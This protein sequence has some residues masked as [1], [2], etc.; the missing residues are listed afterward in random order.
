MVGGVSGL[1]RTLLHLFNGHGA[2]HN[3]EKAGLV[4]GRPG[5]VMHVF[6]KVAAV[7]ADEGALHAFY[8]CKGSAGLKPCLLCTNVYQASSVRDVVAR[9][10]TGVSVSHTCSDVSLL[11]LHTSAT[12]AAVLRAL[13][14]LAAQPKSKG[15]LE[16][17]E[18]CLGWRH[19]P[20]ALLSDGWLLPRMHPGATCIFDWMHVIFVNGIFGAAVGQ[21]MWFAM[22]KDPC[23]CKANLMS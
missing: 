23:P 21:L 3:T 20:G 9:D 6:A 14:H 17:L 13:A 12:V 4:V 7:V 16:E 5:R 1:F 15:K 22:H 8:A 19:D 2:E 11:K 10:A 18:T